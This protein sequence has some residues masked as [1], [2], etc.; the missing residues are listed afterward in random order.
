MDIIQ[1]I[2]SV[3]CVLHNICINMGHTDV[4][5]FPII[6]ADAEGDQE[7]PEPLQEPSAVRGRLV[8]DEIVEA[9]ALRQLEE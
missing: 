2:I 7:W 1:K 9:F 4:D 8:R 6:P 3:C 5:D